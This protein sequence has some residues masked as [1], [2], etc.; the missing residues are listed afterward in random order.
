VRI[1]LPRLLLYGT[2]ALRAAS[3][4]APG[5]SVPADHLLSVP[6][7]SRTPHSLFAAKR[8]WEAR[9][10]GPHLTLGQL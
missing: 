1:S 2:A 10:E 3:L 9:D 7:R 8:V 5:D 4:Q 6:A